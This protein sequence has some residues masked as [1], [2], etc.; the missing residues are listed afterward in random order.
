MIYADTRRV[1]WRFA[2]TAPRF[3]GA[4][5]VLGLAAALTQPGVPHA[6]TPALMLAMLLKLAC[7]LRALRP[8]GDRDD[9]PTP[10]RQTA[11]LLAG[12]LRLVFGARVLLALGGGVALPFAISVHAVPSA[13]AWLAL[14]LVL[15][16]ELAERYLFFR[17]VDAPKMPGVPSA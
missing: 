1:F 17:A 16:G 11:R 10:E 7:E 4:A 12:P 6:V 9:P 3:F 8:L 13:A 14:A 15:V 5:A 2:Q